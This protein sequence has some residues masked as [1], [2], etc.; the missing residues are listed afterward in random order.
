[1][2]ASIVM[3]GEWEDN[4]DDPSHPI[5]S[6]TAL[7]IQAIK[8]GGGSDLVIVVASPLQ[9]DERSQR[10]LLSKIEMYLGFLSTPEFQSKSGVAT[11]QNTSI[12]VQIHP[13]SD[14]AIFELIERCKPWFLS[15]NAS[16]QVKPLELS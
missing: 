12:I 13:A 9:S 6:L 16:L 1:M 7:D 4:Y 8:I 15:N 14:K 3:H 10:R 11:S 2:T 5:P